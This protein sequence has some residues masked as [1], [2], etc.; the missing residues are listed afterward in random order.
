M[1]QHVLMECEECTRT[2]NHRPPCVGDLNGRYRIILRTADAIGLHDGSPQCPFVAGMNEIVQW[3][4]S[5]QQVNTMGATAEAQHAIRLMREILKAKPGASHR[6]LGLTQHQESAENFLVTYSGQATSFQRG[7]FM[8]PMVNMADHQRYFSEQ[9]LDKDPSQRSQQ[10]RQANSK[11]LGRN[12][13]F[14]V[15]AFTPGQFVPYTDFPRYDKPQ[16][17]N[18]IVDWAAIA[19]AYDRSGTLGETW[20][21]AGMNQLAAITSGCKNLQDAWSIALNEVVPAHMQKVAPQWKALALEMVGQLVL[22]VGAIGL[23]LGFCAVIGGVVGTYAAPGMGTVAGAEAGMQFGAWLVQVV[24]GAMIIRDVTNLVRGQGAAISNG[25]QIAFEGQVKPGANQ[26]GEAVG[27][28][29]VQLIS[30]LITELIM[31]GAHGVAAKLKLRT[32]KAD[33]L[34]EEA[35]AKKKLSEPLKQG[36][37][38]QPRPKAKIPEPNKYPRDQMLDEAVRQEYRKAQDLFAKA[39]AQND[40]DLE[41]E[42]LGHYIRANRGLHWSRWMNGHSVVVTDVAHFADESILPALQHMKPED[43]VHM[44]KSQENLEL[45]HDQ[46]SFVI[47]TAKA[48]NPGELTEAAVN[49]DYGS[50]IGAKDRAAVGMPMSNP[51]K[52]L[53]VAQLKELKAIVTKCKENP[54]QLDTEMKNFVQ[55][56]YYEDVKVDVEVTVKGQ[57]KIQPR[58]AYAPYSDTTGKGRLVKDPKGNLVRIYDD[59]GD[60]P[61]SAQKKRNVSKI[62]QWWQSCQEENIFRAGETQEGMLRHAVNEAHHNK[63]KRGLNPAAAEAFHQGLDTCHSKIMGGRPY[64]GGPQKIFGKLDMYGKDDEKAM[65]IIAQYILRKYLRNKIHYTEDQV[66]NCYQLCPAEKNIPLRLEQL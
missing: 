3:V 8:R 9:G 30:I 33:Q 32:P 6:D 25:S 48:A 38:D 24:C 13:T 55:K 34:L 7:V 53:T 40:P 17:S 26:I 41:L 31:R 58:Q 47:E 16:A 46:A 1:G 54:D 42:A 22:Q 18:E 51:H 62:A 21:R 66:V 43:L 37:L 29:L 60:A 61:P 45:T 63:G 14:R 50:G 52:A 11:E 28:I 27:D 19:K 35:A 44:L 49:H 65:I 12:V 57:K 59:E 5:N 20:A 39:K 56:Y 64:Q 2:F 36:G 23:T 4:R 10:Q 15:P